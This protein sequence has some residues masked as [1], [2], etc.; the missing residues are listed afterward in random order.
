MRTLLDR[1][2]AWTLRIA[3]L[4]LIAVAVLIAVQLIGRIFDLMLKL[5]GRPAYGF[6]VASLAEM[7][8]YLLAAA[9]F[10]ALASTLKRGAHIRVTMLLSALGPRGRRLLEL[11]AF[12]ASAAFVAF[13]TWSV[14]R[15]AFD[16]L[17]FDEIS[18]GLVAIPLAIPQIAMAIG[19][20]ALLVALVDEFFLVWNNGRSSFSAGEDAIALGKEG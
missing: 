10:L 5:A 11:W 9:T 17:R 8:G 4:C 16:S 20:F 6:M 12:A 18:Y 19:L 2:Y 1:L 3:A 15:L 14:V 7:A 13:A